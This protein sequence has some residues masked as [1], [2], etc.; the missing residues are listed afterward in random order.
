M[1][2]DKLITWY[3]EKW[4]KENLTTEN[5]KKGFEAFCEWAS[6]PNIREAW[7][8]LAKFCVSEIIKEIKEKA[9]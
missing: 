8:R 9:K 1:I 5:I 7:G 2:V 3:A 6:D 4:V